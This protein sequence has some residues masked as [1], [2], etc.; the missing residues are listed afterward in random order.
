MHEAKSQLPRLLRL[1]EQGETVVITSHGQA[2]AEPIPVRC[3]SGFPFGIAGEEPLVGVGDDRWQP[4]TDD[5]AEDRVR[6]QS[7]PEQR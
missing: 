1:V 4:M 5:E 6:S 3:P 2:V 7:A